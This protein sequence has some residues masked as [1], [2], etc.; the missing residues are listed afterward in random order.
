M[1]GLSFHPS[2][3]YLVTASNDTTLKVFS[4]ICFRYLLL[5]NISA[6]RPRCTT[7]S[8]AM[9]KPDRDHVAR[10]ISSVC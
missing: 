2:G 5:G 3:N 10:F 6:I 4:A 8:A 7:S 1:N 9:T